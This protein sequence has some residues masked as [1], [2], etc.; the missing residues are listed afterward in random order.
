MPS[1]ERSRGLLKSFKIKVYDEDTDYGLLRHVL[2]RT[3]A[4]DRSDHGGAGDPFSDLPV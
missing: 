2:I 1:S 3:G 4:E